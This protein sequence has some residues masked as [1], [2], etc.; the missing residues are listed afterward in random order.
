M[1]A[2]TSVDQKN[3]G[4]QG[5]RNSSFSSITV[6]ATAIA[7][8]PLCMF[9]VVRKDLAKSLQW[10]TGSVITQACH[11]ATA[12]LQQTKDDDNTKEYLKDIHNMRKVV[13]E[14]KNAASLEKLADALVEHEIPLFRW[15]EQ[16]ENIVT[17]FAT[18][19]LRERSTEVKAIFKKYSSLYR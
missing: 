7:A 4:R 5:Y 15:T 13:L 18:A 14:T 6:M 16:P 17:A 9:I 8:E 11:A 1:R 3:L 10:P 12:I 2:V 19:P